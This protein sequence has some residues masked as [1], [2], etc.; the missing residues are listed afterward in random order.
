VGAVTISSDVIENLIKNACVGNA[1]D[2]F[3]ADF[4]VLCSV[5]NTMIDC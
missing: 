2:A 3:I 5:G 1:V 4:E